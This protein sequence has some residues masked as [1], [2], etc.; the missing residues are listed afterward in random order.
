[1][2]EWTNH[3]QSVIYKL[4]KAMK[5]FPLQIKHLLHKIKHYKK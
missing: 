4:E 2:K 1:L 3:I 5:W